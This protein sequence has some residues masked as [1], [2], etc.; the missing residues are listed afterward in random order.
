MALYIYGNLIIFNYLN[1]NIQIYV[2]FRIN[3]YILLQSPLIQ[4]LQ[5][6]STNTLV[7]FD[8]L[9]NLYIVFNFKDLVTN[10]VAETII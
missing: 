6:G 2:K 10:L 1:N 8:I 4:M 9:N 3:N 7:C 5:L